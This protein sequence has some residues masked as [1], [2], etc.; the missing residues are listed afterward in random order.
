MLRFFV[1]SFRWPSLAEGAPIVAL[2]ASLSVPAL[3]APAFAQEAPSATV[4]WVRSQLRGAIAPSSTWT[5][6]SADTRVKAGDTLKTGDDS[7]AELVMPS[8]AR[9]TLGAN[10]IVR[11]VDL[12]GLSPRVMT[13]RIHLYA[14]PQGVTNLAAST[15]HLS[16]T[17]AE[18]VVERVGGVWRVG[19][20]AGDFRVIDASG[21]PTD[22][23][24]G[25]LVTFTAEGPAVAG[26]T[27]SQSDDLQLGFGQGAG[28]PNAHATPTPEANPPTAST[29]NSGANK[30]VAT[31]LSTLLPGAGQLYAG[32]VP[33]GL[34]YLGLD[35]ALLGTG[36]YGHY[37]AQN[38]LEQ[39]AAAGLLGLNLISPL[40]A[41]LT[42]PDGSPNGA[43]ATR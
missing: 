7:A 24:A 9:V 26:M 11:L 23:D 14:P 42:T 36:F 12:E 29:G 34:L 25:K 15:F 18:A 39:G 41:L 35:F 1:G 17:D 8:G 16:G 32:E 37:F 19:V 38:T 3:V 27:R 30:W 33:R 22:V 10:T 4:I 20:L 5:P 43:G 13:G 40:D 28:V 21:N 31:T 6:L 2:L